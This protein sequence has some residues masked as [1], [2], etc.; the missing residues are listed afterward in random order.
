MEEASVGII[1]PKDYEIN[2]S[3]KCTACEVDVNTAE[4]LECS[5][6]KS[7]FHTVCGDHIPFANK[8]F[9]KSFK[10]LRGDYFS[11]TCYHCKT[12][13]ETNAASTVQ[14]QIQ[15]LTSVVNLLVTQFLTLSN[16][17]LLSTTLKI[18][19]L[20]SVVYQKL[21]FNP[22]KVRTQKQSMMLATKL[23]ILFGMVKEAEE[24][25]F[26]KKCRKNL[27][28]SQLLVD[29]TARSFYWENMLHGS[30]PV[31]VKIQKKL[32][33]SQL[34]LGEHAARLAVFLFTFKITFL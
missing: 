4:M 16:F 32:H 9:I 17:T 8:S 19:M 2:A 34:L 30:Q 11:F 15:K 28:G 5:D 25:K 18:I 20:I 14:E 22:L 29:S 3:G 13:R 10:A 1:A 21:G 33:G 23:F 7:K 6:C 27:H 24:H 26:A 31:F 12:R